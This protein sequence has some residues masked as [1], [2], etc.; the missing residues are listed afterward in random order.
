MKPGTISDVAFGIRDLCAWM[1]ETHRHSF[2][3]LDGDASEEF[4]EYLGSQR[5]PE[6]GDESDEGQMLY[7]KA[8]RPLKVWVHLWNQADALRDAGIP[9]PPEAPLSGQSARRRALQITGDPNYA[10]FQPLP[11]EVALPIM[12]AAQRFIGVPAEDL[13]R[14]RNACR[15]EHARCVRVGLLPLAARKMVNRVAKEFEFSV[16][17]GDRESWFVMPKQREGRDFGY[18]FVV[19]RLLSDL[20]AAGVIVLQSHT[21]MRINEICGILGGTNDDTGLPACISSR[22]SKTGLNELFYVNGTLA[23]TVETPVAEEWL[24]GSRPVGSASVPPPVRAISVL[25][26]LCAPLRDANVTTLIVG[27]AN[28]GGSFTLGA[29]GDGM[30]PSVPAL[31]RTQRDFVEKHVDLSGLP[32]ANQ[33]QENLA[34]YRDSRGTCLKTHQWRSTFASYVVGVDRRMTAAVAQHFRH[35]SLAMTEQGYIRN[36]PELREELDAARAQKTAKFFWSAARG[37]APTTGE[38]SYVVDEHRGEV[39]AVTEGKSVREA[40]GALATWCTENDLRLWF[41]APGKCFIEHSP[42]D[43]LCHKV[44]GTSRWTNHEPNY[45]ASDPNTCASCK[46]FAVDGEHVEFWRNRYVE[47]QKAWKWAVASGCERDFRVAKARADQ[48]AAILQRLQEPIPTLEIDHA[49]TA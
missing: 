43:A 20:R 9:A 21:G 32:D 37:D 42:P 24:L 31:R 17:P 33:W 25:E 47:N 39:E 41:S 3:D 36:R 49:T 4:V 12:E 8:L 7:Y 48:S 18:L 44:A 11:D 19:N 23:K 40:I 5:A 28:G 1:V 46:C 16:I 14:L 34:G 29:E 30:L 6:G 22:R 27:A 35:L 15:T 38:F 45:A 26:R 10:G 2:S 13:L